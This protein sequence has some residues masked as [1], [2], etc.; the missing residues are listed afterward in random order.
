MDLF[1]LTGGQWF[2]VMLHESWKNLPKN[3][4]LFGTDRVRFKEEGR[5]PGLKVGALSPMEEK[6]A[7]AER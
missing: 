2:M 3:R 7:T 6:A 5:S 1:Y 4:A